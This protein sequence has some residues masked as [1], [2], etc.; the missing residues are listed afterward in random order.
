MFIAR[1]RKI[2]KINGTGIQ[3]IP[4]HDDDFIDLICNK[5]LFTGM[6]ILDLGA[7]GLRFAIPAAQKGAV[8]TAVD[9]DDEALDLTK[10]ANRVNQNGKINV[11][12]EFIE[13]KII[14]I[15]KDILN[16][17]GESLVTYDLITCFRALHFFT[18]EQ[19]M[20]FFEF[21]DNR[22]DKKGILAVSAMTQDNFSRPDELNEFFL[23]SF[24][25][26]N[27]NPLYRKFNDTSEAIELRQTQNLPEKIHFI[28]ELFITELANK[29]G[30]DLKESNI[31]STRVVKGYVLKKV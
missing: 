2:S 6:R 29:Y 10:I 8:V 14:T 28:S 13:D 31:Q 21:I 23:N 11:K 5:Y 19:I 27:S 22:I 17:L 3:Y 18:P 26:L 16:F 4:G 1:E 9:L 30:Y 20:R 15:K 7:G 12:I 25:L 24:P